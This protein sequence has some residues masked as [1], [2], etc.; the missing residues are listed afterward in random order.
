[1]AF[2]QKLCPTLFPSVSEMLSYHWQ[3]WGGGSDSW[4][5]WVWDLRSPKASIALLTVRAGDQLVPGQD[6]ALLWAVEL[7]FSSFWHQPPGRW[8]WSRLSGGWGGACP[9]CWAEL[10]LC[11]AVGCLEVAVA[12]EAFRHPVCWAV[13]CKVSLQGF[14]AVGRARSWCWWA[15]GSSSTGY[16]LLQSRSCHQ[17]LH[18]QG[19]LQPPLPTPPFS[20]RLFQNIK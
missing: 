18:P 15:N 7:W 13:W 10:G 20:G 14:Q 6:L 5:S 12:Q 3:S 9:P 2:F 4:H 16:R 11:P 19:E 1:M 17:C 8:G